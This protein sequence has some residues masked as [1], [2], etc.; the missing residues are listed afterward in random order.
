V[1]DIV[2]TAEAKEKAD[3]DR[4]VFGAGSPRPR[5]KAKISVHVA[6]EKVW[7]KF[8]KAILHRPGDTLFIRQGYFRINGT[9]E[10]FESMML[11]R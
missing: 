5:S 2:R 9:E 7:L 6:R 8:L 3:S 11:S 4:S 1:P 10:V